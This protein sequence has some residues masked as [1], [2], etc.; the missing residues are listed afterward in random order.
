MLDSTFSGVSLVALLSL[1]IPIIWLYCLKILDLFTCGRK[2]DEVAMV[3]M[4]TSQSM[5]IIPI[6]GI[7]D[8]I[9]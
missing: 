8:S 5:F 4:N 7:S 2:K 3:D 9:H 6:Q 1:F